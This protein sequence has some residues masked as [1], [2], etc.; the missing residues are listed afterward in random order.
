[1]KRH[2]LY[3]VTTLLAG[4]C[5]ALA[6][7][8]D[9]DTDTG[10]NL[11]EPNFP[12]PVTPTV[13]A[14][15]TYLLEIDPAPNQEWE[16]SI[17]T[18]FAPYFWIE[19]GSQN[20]YKIRGAAGKAEVKIG[21]AALEEFDE[22]R[23]CEVTMRMGGQ[24]KVIATITRGTLEREFSLRLC[25][26]EDN[27]FAYNPE[28][29]SD[30]AYDY[31]TQTA[32]VIDLRW[33]EGRNGFML[34]ILIEANFDW[35]IKQMPEWLSAPEIASGGAGRKL[36][37]R[38][39]GDV[40]KY[41][42]DGD[43]QGKIVFCDRNNPEASYEFGMSIPAC[44]D[45][46]RIDR[47]SLDTPLEFNGRGQFYANNS[48]VDGGALGYITSSEEAKFF[49]V[50][51]D[52]KGFYY[53]SPEMTD[54]VVIDPQP[55][56]TVSGDV[57]QQREFTVTTEANP[58]EAPRSAELL[59]LPP[60]LAQ[61]ISDPDLDLFSGDCKSIKEEYLPFLFAK[62]NQTA[63]AGVIEALDPVAM[64]GVGAEFKPISAT[65]W[66]ST[67]FG[68]PSNFQLTYT[69]DWSWEESYLHIDRETYTYEIYGYDGTSEK[70][71]PQNCWITIEKSERGTVIRMD[72]DKYEKPAGQKESFIVFSDAEG[73]FAMVYCIYDP[74]AQ[75]G[76]GGFTAEFAY[77]ELVQGATLEAITYENIDRLAAAYPDLE[78]D[79][80]ENL[81]MDRPL[82]ILVYTTAEPY[83]AVIS[84]S[85]FQQIMIM[86]MSGAEWCN[87]EPQ[88]SSVLFSMEKP[89]AD[90]EQTAKAE[91]V[92]AGSETIGFIYCIPA[93]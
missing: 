55:W 11:P 81:S 67:D 88:G 41:P 86:P 77:P 50:V 1:M 48:W 22:N 65:D 47:I 60:S 43:D 25:K 29:D 61:Q 28:P 59:A 14:G 31:E 75:I 23:S 12:Q 20:V 56:N 42:L 19:D 18:S 21:V 63:A 35:H 89:A 76:G 53:G 5:L 64:L 58:A 57:M 78:D 52:D 68:A 70:L 83:N 34:P 82:Y 45:I 93:F 91:F 54:W 26:M 85:G 84:T 90:Q 6:S 16:I 69:K 80:R 51:K 71:D 32:S 7:C 8:S 13:A 27:D 40:S 92:G 73:V 24:T 15:D 46:L 9:S 79:M 72:P 44:R 36:E 2:L 62:V 33:P 30:I 10:S 3:L 37:I 66:P 39:Q 74:N 17:S 87:Y 38:L 49:T 4:A